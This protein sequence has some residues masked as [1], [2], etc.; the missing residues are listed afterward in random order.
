M[1]IKWSLKTLKIKDLHAHPKNPRTLSHHQHDHLKKN[2]D[3]FGLIDKPCVNLD[4]QIIGGHQ[5][6]QILKLD[7]VKE[8][9]CWVPERLLS[10]IEVDKLLLG[11][12]HDHGD[13]CYD[14]LSSHFDVPFLLDRGFTFDELE[15]DLSEPKPK[16][17]KQKFC[18]H[19]QEEIT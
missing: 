16:K 6:I 7:G 3:E 4:M 10:E 13:F 2:M 8:V 11:L 14:T 1:T 5:R 18:P 9:E 17:K 19:C 12:N 15:I